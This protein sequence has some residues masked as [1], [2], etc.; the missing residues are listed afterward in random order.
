MTM[1]ETSHAAPLIARALKSAMRH[2]TLPNAKTCAKMPA[3]IVNAGNPVA[4][5]MPKIQGT[6]CASPVSQYPTAPFSEAQ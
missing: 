4:C 2:A 3:K 6:T 1:R 5:M